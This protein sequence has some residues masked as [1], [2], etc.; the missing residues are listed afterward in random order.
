MTQVI[1]VSCARSAAIRA[2][3]LPPPTTITASGEILRT[4]VLDGVQSAFLGGGA[5]G[6]VAVCERR[7]VRVVAARSGGHTVRHEVVLADRTGTTDGNRSREVLTAL[8]PVVVG[9]D[10]SAESLAAVP[11]RP[12]LLLS[13]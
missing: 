6:V 7:G 8:R 10:G 1:W 11:P 13:Q 9:L 5:A 2:P 4:R 12:N 3:E